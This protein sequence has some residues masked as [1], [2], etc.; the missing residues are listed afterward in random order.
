VSLLTII[1]QVCGRLA[2]TVPT[3]V[4]GST[5]SQVTQLY[6]LANKAGLDLAQAF[7]WQALVEEQ[8]F[9]T[10]ATTVQANAIPSDFDR[11]IPNSFFNRT[12]MRPIIGPVTPQQ[13]QWLIAQPA[14][15][16][17]YLMYRERGG[18]FL[19]GPPSTPPPAGDTIAFEYISEN[20]AKSAAITPV[21]QSSFLADTDTSYL[22]ENLIADAVVWMFLRAKGLSYAEEMTTYRAEPRPGHGAGRRVHHA[23]SLS[24]RPVDINRVNLPDGN[25]PSA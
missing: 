22:D 7:N 24:P 14:Y 15:S 19:M 23:G 5:D 3:T 2:L 9:V 13:W 11:F 25:F 20:W 1:A 17:V 12:T 6:T 18:Q 8:T 10:T 16:T 4:V 21:P